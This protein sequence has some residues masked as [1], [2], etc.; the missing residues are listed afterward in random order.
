MNTDQKRIL[1]LL[2]RRGVAAMSEQ[3]PPN[4]ALGAW[5]TIAALQAEVAKELAEKAAPAAPPA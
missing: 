2:A 3:I 4:D 5:Q 1:L